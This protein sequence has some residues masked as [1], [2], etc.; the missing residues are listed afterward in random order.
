MYKDRWKIIN[1]I[2]LTAL[3][4]LHPLGQ[5]HGN[6]T[7]QRMG[8]TQAS[9][10]HMIWTMI[11]LQKYMVDWNRTGTMMRDIRIFL[12]QQFNQDLVNTN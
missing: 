2:K 6:A 12:T 7:S 11:E 4:K 3:E 1:K 10:H 5:D 8:E 9:L